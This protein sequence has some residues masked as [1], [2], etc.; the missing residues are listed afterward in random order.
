MEELQR[1]EKGEKRDCGN[2]RYEDGQQEKRVSE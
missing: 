2:A 1:Q